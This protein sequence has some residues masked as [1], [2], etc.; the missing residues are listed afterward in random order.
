MTRDGGQGDHSPARRRRVKGRVG[1]SIATFALLVIVAACLKL[2]TTTPI[3]TVQTGSMV[4]T[5]HI[6]DV[7]L[8]ESLHGH[9]PKVGQIVVAPVPSGVQQELGYPAYVTHRVVKIKDGQLT[10]KGDANKA[11]DPFSVPLSKIHTRVVTVIPGAGRLIR[12]LVSPFG[13]IWLVFGGIV[14]M[15][16]KVLA[17]VRDGMV[18]APGAATASGGATLDELVLAVREY[19]Q[20][21]QSHTAIVQA[22]AE[23]SRQLSSVAARLELGTTGGTAVPVRG[24]DSIAG[25]APLPAPCGRPRT[26]S[27]GSPCLSS[28][29]AASPPSVAA[30]LLIRGAACWSGS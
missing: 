17:L 21:L 7:I 28:P 13:I 30:A 18:P 1:A 29:P 15:G 4:P 19:G 5:F 11:D 9:A 25:P 20:H 10:T 14:F 26:F 16:P 8:T 6:G 3:E 24:P 27:C 23:A 2:G 12:F 22:M